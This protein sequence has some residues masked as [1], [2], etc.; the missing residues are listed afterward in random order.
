[1]ELAIRDKTQ[2]LRRLEA[3]RNALN[4]RVRLLREELTLL[5]EPGSYV[6]EV[7]KAMGKKKVLVKVGGEG[8]YIVDLDKDIDIN[9][10]T[11][12][13]RVALRNDSYTLHRIL[14]TKVDPLVSLMKVEK[15]PD[16]T[17][18]MVGGLDKQIQEIK[19]VI[20]LPIKHPE[21][22]EAL[23]VA[24]PKV[25]VVTLTKAFVRSRA[26]ARLAGGDRL[27]AL[28]CKIET[29]G[30]CNARVLRM[31]KP[32]GVKWCYFIAIFF[33]GSGDGWGMRPG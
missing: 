2:N 1:M 3:Q 20:E 33:E 27:T 5:Q 15:V 17:Y 8:K 4:G 31:G 22:F 14:P 23:G 11:P 12:G 24:Q 13:V 10:C 16:A 29:D 18:D 32:V 7:V 9:A 21:L 26:R 28:P 30:G 25:G 6:G 19:E